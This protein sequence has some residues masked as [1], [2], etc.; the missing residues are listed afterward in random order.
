MIQI[1]VSQTLLDGRGRGLREGGRDLNK[2]KMVNKMGA[3]KVF[4][5]EGKIEL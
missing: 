1:E 2:S 4:Y 3:K 5:H